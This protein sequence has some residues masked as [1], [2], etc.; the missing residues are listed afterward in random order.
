M[1]ISETTRTPPPALRAERAGF[2]LIELLVVLAVIGILAA[3]LLPALARARGRAEAIACINN[4]RQ[5]ALGWLLYSDDHDG[6][7]PYNL[8]LYGTSYRTDLNWVNNVL[9][10]DL[11]SDNTNT[12]TVTGASLGAYFVNPKIVLCPSDRTLSAAQLAAGWNQRV[13][14]YSMNAMMGDVGYYTARGY[15]LNNPNYLQ[16]FKLTQITQPA[17]YFVFLDEHPDSITDGYFLDKDAG[18]ASSPPPYGESAADPA[19]GQEWLQ[20]PAS[21]HNRCA[22]FSF[23]D[24]HGELHRWLDPETVQPIQ[25]NVPF[26]P[27]SVT[28]SGGDFQW[29]LTHM[30]L[31]IN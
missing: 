12:A 26:L 25:P 18:S 9:T 1:T 7:L 5:L 22:A 29:V 17:N 11:S 28:S 27:V 10:W 14:S 8:V 20:L 4:T 13:R 3:L 23:A 6:A 16:Y 21:Y 31:K 24:G 2:T 19:G 30:S 15:N